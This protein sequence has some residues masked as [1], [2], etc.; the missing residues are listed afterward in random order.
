MPGLEIRY[1]GFNT[2][3]PIVKSKAV[4]QAMAQVINRGE[5]VSKV[6]GSQAE[7]LYSLVPATVT[8]HSNSFF[9]KYGDPS[10]AKA[11]SLLAAADITTPVKLTLHY[12]TDH[13]GPATKEEFERC[14]SS[15][16]TAACSTSASRATPW[17]DVPPGRAEGRVRRLRHGLVPGL[18]RRRQL[19]RAVP[20]QG[21]LPRLAVRQRRRSAPT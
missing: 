20:R 9:N 5:L 7:P 17:D 16:T 15:S 11:K 14:R 4:R 21:Q 18:P 12:T 19:P 6:Y 10:I 13:Y 1:L 3:A 8:G 2:N